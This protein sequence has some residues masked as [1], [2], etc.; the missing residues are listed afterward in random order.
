MS[1]PPR[2]GQARAI[3]AQRDKPIDPQPLGKDLGE[4]ATQGGGQGGQD[5][6]GQFA[7]GLVEAASGDGR[8]ERVM[9]RFSVPGSG[10]VATTMMTENGSFSCASSHSGS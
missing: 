6:A 5:R 3:T 8:V 4:A 7:Q 9:S 10:L 1:P 2:A